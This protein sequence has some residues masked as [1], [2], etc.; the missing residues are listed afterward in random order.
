LSEKIVLTTQFKK[1]PRRDRLA[2]IV[3]MLDEMRQPTRKSH[4][5]YK[6][7]ITYPI[8]I[9]ELNAL[10]RAGCIEEVQH[11]VYHST[12]KGK[13]LAEMLGAMLQVMVE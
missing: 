6:C 8:L 5:I 11:Y 2:L 4:L 1:Q 7:Q 3:S 13:L 9:R 12:E 10:L